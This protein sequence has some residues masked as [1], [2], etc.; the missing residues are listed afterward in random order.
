[1]GEP[2]KLVVTFIAGVG[3]L[4]GGLLLADWW[5]RRRRLSSARQAWTLIGFGVAY[6]VFVGPLCVR[7]AWGL[8]EAAGL[9][10]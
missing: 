3:G 1:M 4:V 2:M 7:I 9:W 5:G 8:A 10:R 6:F